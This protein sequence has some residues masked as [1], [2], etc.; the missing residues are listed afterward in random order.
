MTKETKKNVDSMGGFLGWIE[1]VGNKI[2][3]PFILFLFL[4]IVIAVVS[5]LV[6][7]ATT[8]N[9][10]TGE[11]VVIKNILSG[12]GISY[13]L[14]SMVTNFTSFAPLGLVLSMTLGIGLA[15]EVGLMSAF[16]RKTI[17]G[18][19]EKFV[20][21][22]I[23]II[24][25]CGNLA[26]D[27]A[28]IIVPTLAAII[29]LYIGKNP[30][31]GIALG[32]AATTAGFSA[33]L[34]VAGTDA[35]LQGIT[36]EASSIVNGPQIEVTA[37]WYIMIAS[38]FVLAVVGTIVNNKI[39][40]PRLG[41]YEG[42]AIV[43][44]NE[45]T[46]EE[47][48]GLKAAGISLLLY[49]AII[50]AV[51]IPENSFMRNPETGSLTSGSTLMAG[52]IPL[53]LFLF[54]IISIAYGKASG[55]IKDAFR[56]VPKI[57]E[58]SI[59]K[60]SAFIVLAFVIGQFIAWFNWTSI[61]EFI[62]IE[63]ANFLEEGGFTGGP[64]FVFYILIVAFINLFIGSGSAKWALLAPIF[65]PMMTLLGYHPAWTQ[66]LYRVGDS[67]TNI[68]SPLFPY[69][70]I[71]LSFMKEYDEEAGAGTLISTMIPYSISMLI[72][73]II[74]ALIWYYF[75]PIPIGVGG[76]IML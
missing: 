41:K 15:E 59:A 18:V 40:E 68:I 63:L 50:V 56:E 5:F 23:M 33:N 54:L 37:N 8:I 1:R 47:N 52:I 29:F 21:P 38:T 31:A 71:I 11:E 64:L 58:T 62:A 74:F 10:A 25:I 6:K 32:Y 27:A 49:V 70:P 28:I 44:K 53:I 19:N 20:V 73:W 12:E 76:Q 42:E 17:L 24:G 14:K 67:A 34:V 60:M 43:E 4:L 51:C 65:V 48:K 26:S 55:V 7:G 2:P 39:I 22:V 61:G 45:I 46:S 35:L 13:A 36:N 75:I 69:F 30:L 3:H 16:M 9:P 72:V 66:F 57:M